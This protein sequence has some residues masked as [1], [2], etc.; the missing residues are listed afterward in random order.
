V[1]RRATISQNAYHWAIDLTVSATPGFDA[2]RQKWGLGHTDSADVQLVR[3]D[4]PCKR[5]IKATMTEEYWKGARI[6]LFRVH[7]I[8]V[9]TFAG[10]ATTRTCSIEISG[11]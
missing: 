10:E 2:S 5:A 7:D 8:Y 3:D 6:A 1:S 9:V 4:A 11:Y